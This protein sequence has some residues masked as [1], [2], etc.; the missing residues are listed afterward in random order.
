MAIY[1]KTGDQG[2]TSLYQGKRVL[3]S[4]PQIEASGSIDELSSFIGLVISIIPQKKLAQQLTLIQKNLYQIMAF[5]SGKNLDLMPLEK[6]V[7]FFEQ[8]IDNST[9]KL[10]KLT[11]FIL[12]QGSAFSGWFH[13]LRTVC[14]RAEI[15]VVKIF[16]IKLAAG[17][18]QQNIIIKFLNR[19]SDFFFILARENNLKKELVV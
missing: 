15:N 10:P 9:L 16:K 8:Y 2:T 17:N 12:P 18:Q 13:V 4:D 1:T 6:T 3:K 11:S 14:R 5:L 7:V 19:L